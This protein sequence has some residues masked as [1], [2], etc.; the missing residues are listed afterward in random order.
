M[1][2][3]PPHEDD[4]DFELEL[5]PLDPE[6]LAVERERANRKTEEAV[7][8]VDIDE[9]LRERDDQGDYYVD[10]SW[11]KSFRFTTRHALALTA[12]LAMALTLFKVLGGCSGLFV[13]GMIALGVSWFF[14]MR[15][16]QRRA[17]ERER[18][19]KEFFASHGG[20]LKTA[21]ATPA[22]ADAAN[23]S[24]PQPRFDV[25][26]SFSLKEMMIAMTAA[27]VFMGLVYQFGPE[28][29]AMTL[30]IIALVGLAVN[31]MGFDPPRMVVLGWW[32]LLVFYLVFGFITSLRSTS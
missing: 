3:L 23:A 11:L 17:A 31:A 29:M 15:A 5:E 27:A 1:P 22:E 28:S 24:G 9:I 16:E 19:R 12:L 20:S 8:K 14:V 2:A 25:R 13:I 32:V 7:A 10:W 26:F 30:G 6:I 21:M 18:I 4:D